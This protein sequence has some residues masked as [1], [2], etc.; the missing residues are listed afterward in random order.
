[1]RK[2][3]FFLNNYWTLLQ[4]VFY[5]DGIRYQTIRYC[6]G[7]FIAVNPKPQQSRLSELFPLKISKASTKWLF[8]CFAN[9]SFLSTV[10]DELFVLVSSKRTRAIEPEPNGPKVRRRM[11]VDIY[12]VFAQFSRETIYVRKHSSARDRK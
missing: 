4:D 12:R 3:K 2:K 7:D 11:R 1:M 6:I 5:I 9:F 8:S 10:I